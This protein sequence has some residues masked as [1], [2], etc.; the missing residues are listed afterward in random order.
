MEIIRWLVRELE[1]EVVL[2][3]GQRGALARRRIIYKERGKEREEEHFI[4]QK[5]MRDT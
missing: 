1:K 4:F 2:F 5:L 3:E